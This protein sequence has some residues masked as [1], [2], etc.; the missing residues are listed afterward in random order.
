M[1]T[2][3]SEIN[4][5]ELLKMFHNFLLDSK[6]EEINDYILIKYLK[7]PKS[8]MENS[9]NL[10]LFINEL[11]NQIT[12]K[13]NIILPFIDP[14]YNLIE[15]YINSDKIDEKKVFLDNKIFIQLIENSFFNRKNL[16]PIYAYF[17]ELYS[18]IDR[19]NDLDDKS[20]K[21]LDGFNEKLNKFPKVINLWKLL[22][23][24]SDNKTNKSLDAIST[25]C[26]LGS[27]L[28]LSGISDLPKNHFLNLKINFQNK[29]FW[30]SIN[31][32]DD[33]ICSSE[34]HQKYSV[35][36]GYMNIK[37]NSIDF[38]FKFLNNQYIAEIRINN[39][40]NYLLNMFIKKI[41]D[42]NPI[43]ILK[44]FY[45]Q[46]K[47]MYIS[48]FKELPN[49]QKKEIVLYSI[50]PFPLKDNGGILFSSEYEFEY[51]P[52]TTFFHNS[53][54]IDLENL[55]IYNQKKYNI[56][57]ELKTQKK[58]FVKV[59]YINYKEKSFH[60][61]D[62]F[63]GIS[64]FLPFLNIINGLYRLYK[65]NDKLKIDLLNDI[66]FLIDLAYN[67]LKIIFIHKI[68]FGIM[69]QMNFTKYWNFYFYL[70]NKIEIF[71]EKMFS[72][73][74][75]EFY[76][77]I[78][79]NDKNKIFFEIFMDF[80]IYINKK[81]E[82]E[83]NTFQKKI[84]NVYFELDS[85]KKNNINLFGKT[86]N[87][88]YRSI[89]KQLF[90]Y[91]RL[92]SKQYLFF[93][94]A[95]LCHKNTNVINHFKIKYKRINYYTSN[96][97]Q[98][99]LFPI[100]EIKNYYPN[101]NKFKKENLYKKVDDKIL[102]YNFSLDRFE[103]NLNETFVKKYLDNNNNIQPINC[104]L[105]K[106]MYHIRGNI[107]IINIK[108]KDLCL[109]FS[110]NEEN[111][112]TCNRNNNE[113]VGYNSNLCYGS[114]FSCLEKDQKILIFI[115]RD[116]I[117]FAIIRIYY[118]RRSG[119]EIFTNNNKSY[120]F[121]FYEELNFQNNNNNDNNCNKIFSFFQD[122]K[123]IKMKK[124]NKFVGWYNPQYYKILSPLFND[125][126]DVWDEKQ[127][128][129]SNFDKLMIINLF[130]N[131]SFNDLNQYPIFP[132][133]YNE[134]SMNIGNKK[135][136]M[137]QHIGFQELTK[138]SI[139]RKELIIESYKYEIM[140]E[141]DN[142]EKSYFNLFYSNI[143]YTC[144]YLIRVFPYSFIGIEY[145]G[146]GFDDPN[147]LFF[148]IKSTFLNTLN[149]R[150]DLRELIPEMFYF[151]QLFYN[152]NEI[153]LNKI[154]TGKEIDNVII[155]DWNEDNLRKYIFLK[156]MKEYLENEKDLNCWIDLIFGVNMEYYKEKE[157]YYNKNNYISFE[158]N[159]E[160]L[161]DDII[162][163]SYDFGVLPF[164][165]FSEKFPKKP[166]FLNIQKEICDLNKRIFE[167]DHIKCLINGKE[168][169]ICKGEK[170][171][172]DEYLKIIDK[173]KEKSLFKKF[174]GLKNLLSYNIFSK[175]YDIKYLF[176]G[177]VFGNLDIYRSVQKCDPVNTNFELKEI[178]QDKILLDQI[179]NKKY[180]LLGSLTDHT[181]E[182]KYIDYNPRLNLVID[183]SLDGYINLYT[184]PK[185]KLIS[186]ILLKDYN[187]NSINNVVLISNPFP[188][189]C[190]TTT[191]KIYV[192]DI[193][194][195]YI[196]E[197]DT[198]IE[199]AQF[200]FYIDKNCGLFND[201]ICY[202]KNGREE[203]ID[204]FKKNNKLK[205]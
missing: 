203:Q 14:L 124:D 139:A 65:N 115:P 18:D 169:F 123:E 107:G 57:I 23:S 186:A 61:I 183:F 91:N 40:K 200:Q 156:D 109:F 68:N 130:S 96:F 201:Y 150:A 153:E 44:N 52:N 120:Y 121:N 199:D 27:G 148:S 160:K 135:R 78:T 85:D 172:N 193:N 13:N 3:N 189:I 167:E 152:I 94:E 36:L 117:M 47:S 39:N 161:K 99:L 12:K 106:K 140:D 45:G 19:L 163:Q 134:V 113:K 22:Y 179:N 70:L 157:R 58:D 127:Y 50:L 97:Q 10:S 59:N 173:I 76:K 122:F 6:K 171:I 176:V 34:Y 197:I 83:E 196:N 72:K 95:N 90:I 35:L 204:L 154:S 80:L 2:P 105:V 128:Y 136:A 119:L 126:I 86:N 73:D 168:T 143:T 5:I 24:Q 159:E 26:F 192:F 164:K 93:K 37:I 190:C 112:Q 62:Y 155:N 104:C 25:F 87:Q 42:K 181:R 21:D 82:I 114:V 137:D 194:G 145:Q 53:D 38:T 177:D 11:S 75:K 43:L 133:L 30:N 15:T 54:D 60:I 20:S 71:K 74:E 48:I 147:R 4:D 81:G 187:I 32:D 17:T 191:S 101:F 29:I 180:E 146:D 162:M 8:V 88:L 16:I 144:N 142:D 102:N 108:Q 41:N 198:E 165:L 188:M 49:N 1:S 170:Y 125:F 28:E 98:P 51:N 129:Y 110:S 33:L 182:I 56:K 149:Q 175:E 66:S 131:R 89:M 174:L 7:D 116:E 178:S 84:I 184:I 69:K 205:K 63:G 111:A 195:K 55:D 67:I 202:I 185:L 64:Q 166:I 118:Y 158:S 141:S 138:E 100:L 79:L 77:Y 92:W 31:E 132:M 46:I 103:N 151:P 9:D